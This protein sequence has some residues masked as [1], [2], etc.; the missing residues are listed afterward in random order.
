[1]L[2][3]EAGMFSEQLLAQLQMIEN[4]LEEPFFTELR[5]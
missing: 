4:Y 1:M 5:T 3:L 2:Y